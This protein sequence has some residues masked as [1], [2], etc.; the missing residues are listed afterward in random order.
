MYQVSQAFIDQASAQT[1]DVFA[2]IDI[3]ATAPNEEDV[4]VTINDTDIIDYTV[5]YPFDS[6]SKP[7]LGEALSATANFRIK[8][9]NL[10][11]YFFKGEVWFKPYV[12]FPTAVDEDGEPTDIEWMPLGVFKVID[13]SS[14]DNYL[15]LDVQAFD[16]I[17]FTD[18]LFEWHDSGGVIT[19]GTKIADV[20]DMICT[21]FDLTL[22]P[23]TVYPRDT[24]G[25]NLTVVPLRDE[26]GND[27]VNTGREWLGWI[28]GL[29]GTNAIIDKD[30][31]LTFKGY[32]DHTDFT[33]PISMSHLGGMRRERERGINYRE[34][35]LTLD[36]GRSIGYE[37]TAYTT[38]VFATAPEEVWKQY[39]GAYFTALNNKLV[40]TF[41]WQTGAQY[42][43]YVPGDYQYR[44]YPQI[45]VGDIV[46]VEYYDSIG[47][48]KTSWFIFSNHSIKVSGGLSATS[49]CYGITSLNDLLTDASSSAFNNAVSG[50]VVPT[51]TYKGG[52]GI[53]VQGSVIS[54]K[55]LL[56]DCGTSTTNIGV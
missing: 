31:Y 24:Y 30:G 54:L 42:D 9:P 25:R 40:E 8:N 5:D 26:D 52:N 50:G 4:S 56:F 29:M 19:A 38:S 28:A 15:T 45:D 23:N 13:T 35:L 41:Q 49:K 18:Q 6:D 16:A 33:I 22:N 47:T 11:A 17:A 7:V 20:V 1:R 39:E 10:Q 32:E 53:Q 36:D 21:Y 43:T 44:C 37:P 3:T 14:T 46:S 48:L 51:I 2:K 27:L 12:G 55:D 34:M